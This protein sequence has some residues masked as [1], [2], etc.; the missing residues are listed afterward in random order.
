MAPYSLIPDLFDYSAVH[1]TVSVGIFTYQ[2]EWTVYVA[3]SQ[4]CLCCPFSSTGHC[5]RVV[6][7]SKALH[8]SARGITTDP[9]SIPGCITT[10]R[11]WSHRVQSHRVAHNW[12][13]VVRF[14][15]WPG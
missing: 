13:S 5:S 9:G 6:Q 12:P 15:V 1:Q 4:M 2:E 3:W 14:K 8:L 10:G 11:D 7:W